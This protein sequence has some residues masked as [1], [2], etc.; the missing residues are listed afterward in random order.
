[1]IVRHALL[2][3]GTRFELVLEDRPLANAI[4]EE[5]GQL[6]LDWHG[7]LNAFSR[8][9]DIGR[10]NAAAGADAPWL[11]L[12]GEVAELLRTCVDLHRATVGAFDPTL[13]GAMRALGHRD[14]VPS[15]PAWGMD[16]L[17]LDGPF[18]RL[19][20]AG[21]EID[22]GG[23]AKGHALDLVGQLLRDH[24]VERSLVHGGTSSAIGIGHAPDGSPWRVR[25]GSDG[26]TVDLTDRA[27]SLS[28]IGGRTAAGGGHVVDPRTGRAVSHRSQAAVIGSSARVCDA[29]ATALLVLD[30]DA[31]GPEDPGYEWKV[32]HTTDA[33]SL[34][35]A[36]PALEEA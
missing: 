14:P 17:E 28:A 2:A 3:M 26:P 6:L 22:L 10:L 20:R 4:A 11:R 33:P 16:A 30:D 31:P 13:G 24:G 27:M 15:E 18:A 35:C 9:S 36:A 1:M 8:G 19:T 23:I 34:A 21:V 7:R 5:A 12:D 29:W 32:W 25:L